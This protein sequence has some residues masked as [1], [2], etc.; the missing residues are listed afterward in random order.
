MSKKLTYEYVKSK[1]EEEGYELLSTEYINSK[2]KLKYKCLNGHEHT[3]TWDDFNS[4][5]R[6]PYCYGNVKYSHAYVKDIFK[7][8]GYT[9]LSNKYINNKQFSLLLQLKFYFK[10]KT[11]DSISLLYC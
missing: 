7:K 2:N 9:L 10:F 5:Y 8:C 6:C 11:L 3:I 1:F 4:G